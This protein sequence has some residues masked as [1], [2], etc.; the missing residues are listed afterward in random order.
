MMNVVSD[1]CPAH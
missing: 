1:T